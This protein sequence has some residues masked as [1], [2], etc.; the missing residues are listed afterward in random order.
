[1]PDAALYLIT[2]DYFD[3]RIHRRLEGTYDLDKH[4][5]QNVARE[6]AAGYVTGVKRIYE[7]IPGGSCTDITADIA[8][9]VVLLMLNEREPVDYE[10][11]DWLHR[12]HPDG[13]R[14]TRGMQ[15]VA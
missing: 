10:I 4:T 5:R 6:I 8:R 7:C 14:S 1:M 12:V 9:D 2:Y 15:G 11:V 3:R 13:V